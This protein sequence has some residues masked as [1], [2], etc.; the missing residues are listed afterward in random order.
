MMPKRLEL[1]VLSLLERVYFLAFMVIPGI[2]FQFSVVPLCDEFLPLFRWGDLL[3]VRFTPVVSR[4][5]IL[6]YFQKRIWINAIKNFFLSLKLVSSHYG[7]F[8]CVEKV[9]WLPLI[10]PHIAHVSVLASISLPFSGLYRDCLV[11]LIMWKEEYTTYSRPSL[12]CEKKKKRGRM[13]DVL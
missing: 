6:V 2:F 9:A 8:A 1:I 10:F 3:P 13:S 5:R 12:T 4:C 7:A 11:E